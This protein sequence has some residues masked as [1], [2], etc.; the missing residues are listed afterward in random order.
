VVDN[1]TSVSIAASTFAGKLH[2]YLAA[3]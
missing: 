2:L 1:Y 3:P